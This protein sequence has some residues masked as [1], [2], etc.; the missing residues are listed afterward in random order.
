MP[1]TN[2][3]SSSSATLR[4]T[5]DNV[6]KNRDSA[7][8]QA[9]VKKSMEGAGV[10]SG[11]FGGMKVDGA[12]DA[13]VSGLDGDRNGRVSWDEY[14]KGGHQLAPAGMKL[15]PAK[16]QDPAHV[17]AAVAALYKD[18]D[19]DG[20]AQL[21]HDELAAHQTQVAERV[22]QSNASTRGDIAARLAMKNLDVSRDG[23]LSKPELS[24]F[25]KDVAREQQTRI[26]PRPAPAA[27]TTTAPNAA[28]T[29]TAATKQPT[30]LEQLAPAPAPTP[31][32]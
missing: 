9:E 4:S 23:K 18:A 5:F 11:F 26:A 30:L 12:T 22:G 15:D 25:L 28:P 32:R 3:S 7:L 27:P 10:G 17:D 16:M 24:G 20:D 21:A 6:D 31:C 13:L 29:T 14:V 2:A 8:T 19:V 1:V